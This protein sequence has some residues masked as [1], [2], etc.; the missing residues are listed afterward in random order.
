MNRACDSIW[1]HSPTF[2]SL[3]HLVDFV[4]K[5]HLSPLVFPRALSWD[6]LLYTS[7]AAD[8]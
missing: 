4:L 6:C 3:L 2:D 5:L 7:D 1:S 8:E